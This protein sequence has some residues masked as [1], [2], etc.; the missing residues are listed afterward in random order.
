MIRC[1][2]FQEKPESLAWFIDPTALRDLTTD[3]LKSIQPAA[4]TYRNAMTEDYARR[5]RM[6]S[7]LSLTAAP[8]GMELV[9]AAVLHIIYCT[10]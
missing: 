6:M 8:C 1:S 7:E 3:D 9:A 10:G 2:V 5:I 4:A